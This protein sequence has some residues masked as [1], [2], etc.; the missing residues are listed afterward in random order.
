MS[1]YDVVVIGGGAAG[2]SAALVLSG[3]HRK[4]L[5]V[6]AGTPRN[7]PAVHPHGYLSRNGFP[8]SELLELGR[9]EVGRYGGGV[10]TGT[11][12]ELVAD[13]NNGFWGR[14]VDGRGVLAGRMV[15]VAGVCVGLRV[16]GGW[17]VLAGRV[18]VVAGVCVG[19]RVVGG[20]RVLAGRVV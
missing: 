19:L 13:G 1:Q 12:T 5:V 15:V 20:W 16:V 10:L 2:L 11:T 14:L 3:A 18:V 7:T 17:R 8:H 6:D 4:V 9:D